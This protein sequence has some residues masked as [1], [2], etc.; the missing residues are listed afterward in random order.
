VFFCVSY[1]KIF[2]WQAWQG[3]KNLFKTFLKMKNQTK[4]LK[5]PC[6]ACQACQ[7]IQTRIFDTG[8]YH[9]GAK[10]SGKV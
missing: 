5:T 4:N 3:E 2:F 9:K 7:N 6:Q 10:C 1:S 8:Q